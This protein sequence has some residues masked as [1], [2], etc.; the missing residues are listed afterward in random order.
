MDIFMCNLRNVP[1]MVKCFEL[2]H[3]LIHQ[4]EVGDHL[5]N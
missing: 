1:F 5:A 3:A 2:L 4:K